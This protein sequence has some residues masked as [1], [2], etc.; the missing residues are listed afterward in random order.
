MQKL[1]ILLICERGEILKSRVAFVAFVARAVKSANAWK[2]G[3]ILRV[4]M[5][6]NYFLLNLYLLLL[7]PEQCFVGYNGYKKSGAGYKVKTVCSR[8]FG[9]NSAIAANGG[10][11]QQR[12]QKQHSFSILFIGCVFPGIRPSFEMSKISENL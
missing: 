6:T 10:R 12:L 9:E 3:V 11:W 2:Y 8:G 5:A 1:E 4:L 7:L